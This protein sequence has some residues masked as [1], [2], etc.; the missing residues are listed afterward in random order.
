MICENKNSVISS[1]FGATLL[2]AMIGF[3]VVGSIILGSVIFG[4]GL[5]FIFDINS[6]DPKSLIHIHE[7]VGVIA[8]LSSVILWGLMLF[9][10][11]KPYFKKE[12]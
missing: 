5:D 1:S 9:F 8:V 4:L 12:V 3:S 7:E 10:I 2:A 6:I 11:A